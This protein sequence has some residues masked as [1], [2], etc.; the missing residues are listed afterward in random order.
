MTAPDTNFVYDGFWTLPRWT[1][2][3]VHVVDGHLNSDDVCARLLNVISEVKINTKVKVPN[4]D[5]L[6]SVYPSFWLGYPFWTKVKHEF[7]VRF[8]IKIRTPVQEDG[9]LIDINGTLR[10]WLR[11]PFTKYRPLWEVLIISGKYY[12]GT[13]F[14][15]RPYY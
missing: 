6:T 8:H 12:N 7:D 3:F 11:S 13:K 1:N 9:K 2:A 15:P 5:R 14:K 4:Y 10:E